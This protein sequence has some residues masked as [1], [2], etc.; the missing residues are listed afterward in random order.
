MTKCLRPPCQCQAE[1]LWGVL[2]D[3]PVSVH[4]VSYTRVHGCDRLH[5]EYS[6]VAGRAALASLLSPHPSQGGSPSPGGPYPRDMHLAGSLGHWTPGASSQ[7][8][9]ITLHK[10]KYKQ[11]TCMSLEV[12]LPHAV[13]NGLTLLN[14]WTWEG[15]K[16]GLAS[17]R[18]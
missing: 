13:L 3:T 12:S 15:D 14:S 16:E 9:P 10:K 2:G 18:V 7:N 6:A 4:T 1:A 8:S 17:T 5:G 11:F